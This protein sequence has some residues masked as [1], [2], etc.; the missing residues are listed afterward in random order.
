M[1]SFCHYVFFFASRESAERWRSKHQGTFFYSLDQAFELGWKL[2]MKAFGHELQRR[3][4][5]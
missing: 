2:V 3:S 4:A 1:A 5:A